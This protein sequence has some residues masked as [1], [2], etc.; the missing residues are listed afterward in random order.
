MHIYIY[1]YIYIYIICPR[2]GA[3][4][5]GVEASGRRQA[6][7]VLVSTA[8]PSA[9]PG[10]SRRRQ[11]MCCPGEH[12]AALAQPRGPVQAPVHRAGPAGRPAGMC[13]RISILVKL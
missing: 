7:P 2:T 10:R 3:H 6:E 8:C 12:M 13:G 1:I 9:S 5:E 11:A 4:L